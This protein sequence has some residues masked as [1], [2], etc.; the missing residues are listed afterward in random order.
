M[1]SKQTRRMSVRRSAS[2]ARTRLFAASLAAMKA[3]MGFATRDSEFVND[4][5]GGQES[6]LSDHQS[7]E[8]ARAVLAICNATHNKPGNDL[9]ISADRM[10]R[11]TAL[12]L[13][14]RGQFVFH[15]S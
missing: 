14:G 5:K 2:G 7:F 3:S 9:V 12:R 10:L 11:V 13:S 8:A 4:G 6:G 15:V 1:R